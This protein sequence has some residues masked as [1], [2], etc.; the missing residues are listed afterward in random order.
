[1]RELSIEEQRLLNKV[2]TMLD[3]VKNLT[4]GVS[5][6][7]LRAVVVAGTRGIGKSYITKKTLDNAGTDYRIIKGHVTPLEL[8]HQLG[9]Y[10]EKGQVVVIDDCEAAL[11]GRALDILKAATDTD[12]SRYVSWP[13]TSWQVEFPDYYF[14]G[15]II[16]LT[17]S[18]LRS[19]VHYKAFLDRVH[20][21]ELQFSSKEIALK[22]FDIVRHNGYASD[23][24]VPEI[25]D[26]L[27]LNMD[28]IDDAMS[29][30]TFK[31]IRELC[32]FSSDWKTLAELT[33]VQGGNN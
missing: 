29:L 2:N 7:I 9:Y 16:V 32:Q 13:S 19:S 5:A 1:M 20:Y 18:L 6:G 8:Y 12:S 26:W 10:S 17:N 33:L 28:K 14:K 11:E 31:K 30:R 25:I 22:L 21:L 24:R 23:E 27:E 4:E 15:G 3:S